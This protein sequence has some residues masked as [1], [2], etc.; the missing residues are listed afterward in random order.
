MSSRIRISDLVYPY[1]I[2]IAR[3]RMEIVRIMTQL[4]VQRLC[5]GVSESSLKISGQESGSFFARFRPL[6]APAS[7]SGSPQLSWPVSLRFSARLGDVCVRARI[8][9]SFHETRCLLSFRVFK[10]RSKCKA[11]ESRRVVRSSRKL[12]SDMRVRVRRL[13]R[14][15]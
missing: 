7:Q 14:Q 3:M 6:F 15:P 12:D 2:S 8:A 11:N 10:P 4:H 5:N 1:A 9:L 13:L